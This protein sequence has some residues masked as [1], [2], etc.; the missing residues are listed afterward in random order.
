V[1]VGFEVGLAVG[2]EVGLA[3]GFN[4]GLDVGRFVGR[5]VGVELDVGGL[6]TLLAMQIS[7]LIHLKSQH[8]FRDLKT[9]PSS[10]VRLPDLQT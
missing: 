7:V 3:V 8:S 4:D 10:E 5:L 1:P 9:L 6:V 2:S